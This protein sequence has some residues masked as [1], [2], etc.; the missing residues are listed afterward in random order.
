MKLQFRVTRKRLVLLV[1][2]VALVTAGGIGYAAI[3]DGNGVFTA[4]RLNGV[5]TIRLIDPSVTPASSLL[6]HCTN[7][8]TKIS[9]NQGGPTGPKGPTGD[10]GLTGDT[11]AG[12]CDRER[13]RQRPRR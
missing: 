1:V 3:P 13:R 2:V 4:C 5:G 12:W 8:E 9:W 11:G 7:L 10:K 6:N